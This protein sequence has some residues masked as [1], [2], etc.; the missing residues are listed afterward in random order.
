MSKTTNNTTLSASEILEL[1]DQLVERSLVILDPSTGRCRLLETVRQYG[2]DRMM[3]TGE[4][5]AWRDRH[6]AFFEDLAL[7]A[8]PNLTGRDQIVWLD[9]LETEH[10]NFRS[11][12][13]WSVDF[14]NLAESGLRICAALS[15][16][17]SVRGHFTEGRQ[18]IARALKNA[19]S[20]A[21]SRAR[22][23]ALNGAGSLAMSQGEHHSAEPL[24]EKALML[25][26][27][28]GDRRGE[29][30]AL[31]ALAGIA[32]DRGDRPT[33]RR[34]QEE[35]LAI[36]RELGDPWGIATGLINVSSY[37]RMEGD[38]DR[39]I[40]LC[41]EALS[42]AR[43][44]G[45]RRSVAIA[46]YQ[47]AIMSVAAGDMEA[48]KRLGEQSVERCRELG[49]GRFT[50]LALA[51]LGNLAID[52]RDYASAEALFSES[53]A[54]NR[55]IGDRRGAAIA[56]TMLGTVAYSQGLLARARGLQ[57]QSLEMQKQLP[58]IWGLA[59]ALS[60]IAAHF[61]GED[62]LR[63]ARLWGAAER[64]REEVCQVGSGAEKEALH[65]LVTAAR[66]RAGEEFDQAWQEGR[67]MSPADAIE[68]ALE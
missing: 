49:D 44:A 31:N 50:A 29:A 32:R 22:I 58:D 28:T 63:A 61:A 34:Y 7:G 40:A 45:D 14:P 53:L 35:T 1:H 13:D 41:E 9:R 12:I 59:Y 42:V 17:W 52:D 43:E 25:A 23:T 67:E 39:A 38:Y 33:G 36:M 27:K 64:C 46:L 66:M 11:A 60:G 8:A 68:L 51:H 20:S 30:L 2:R 18:Q 16:F 57:R 65:R 6:L 19:P 4:Q 3:E 24:L 55:D 47:M 62:P 15:R 56:L 5:A 48:A 54:I 10:D 21:D 37:S 26:K